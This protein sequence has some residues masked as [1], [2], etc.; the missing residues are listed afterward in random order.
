[1]LKVVDDILDSFS[2][3]LCSQGGV[4]PNIKN[5]LLGLLDGRQGVFLSLFHLV[6]RQVVSVVLSI[7]QCVF[8]IAYVALV[9]GVNIVIVALRVTTKLH[10]TLVGL[11]LLKS[12]LLLQNLELG[13]R[14]G[15]V[16][17]A[18][19]RL[20]AEVFE[21]LIHLVGNLRLNGQCVGTVEKVF[22]FRLKLLDVVSLVYVVEV[23]ILVAVR[24]L[25]LALRPVEVLPEQVLR[26]L[27]NRLAG[28]CGKQG[29]GSL[30]RL[31]QQLVLLLYRVCG[32]R[33]GFFPLLRAFFQGRLQLLP[34]FG[35]LR[36]LGELN[37]VGLHLKFKNLLLLLITLD[38]VTMEHRRKGVVSVELVVDAVPELH[39]VIDLVRHVVDAVDNIVPETVDGLAKPCHPLHRLLVD[40]LG[41]FHKS[42][43]VLTEDVRGAVLLVLGQVVRHNLGVVKNHVKVAGAGTFKRAV[44]LGGLP[45][46]DVVEKLLIP[47]LLLLARRLIAELRVT[48]DCRIEELV[49][50]LRVCVEVPCEALD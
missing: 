25:P 26:P 22:V 36:G 6:F 47:S 18:K 14:I 30:D 49:R 27:L 17:S 43:L 13:L 45:G 7:E 42:G 24:K 4:R 44:P 31:L 39:P 12:D 50:G 9:G 5:R 40:R 20:L 1:M 2:P 48:L 46:E 19:V 8:R 21:L 11:R 35:L 15:H 41:R 34:V 23:V 33:V 37:L 10:L 29:L 16:V 32:F 38:R 28:L 3:L